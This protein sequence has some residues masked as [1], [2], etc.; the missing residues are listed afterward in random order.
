MRRA[1]DT[2]NITHLDHCSFFLFA[3]LCLYSHWQEKKNH[4]R[5][6][7]VGRVSEKSSILFLF[8]RVVNAKR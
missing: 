4:A 3:Q 6:N 8:K 1:D 7:V 5:P 2:L